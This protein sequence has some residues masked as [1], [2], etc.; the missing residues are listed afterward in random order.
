MDREIEFRAWDKINGI[1]LHRVTVYHPADHIGF[2]CGNIS[3]DY[4]FDGLNPQ[5]H[6]EFGDDWV[7]VMSDFEL[8]Q[9]TGLEEKDG[10]KLDWWEDDLFRFAD[11]VSIQQI[12]FEDGCFS[13][14]HTQTGQKHH[15]YETLNWSGMPIK[16]GNIHTNPE[17]LK[18]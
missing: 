1:M 18:S 9:R 4:G 5:P 12:V 2:P 7:F 11:R 3:E 15:C 16:I 8:M 6:I 13:F 17:L 14:K 10:T